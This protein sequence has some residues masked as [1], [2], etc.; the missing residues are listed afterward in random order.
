MAVSRRLRFEV[1]RRDGHTCRYCGA[2]APDVVLTVD[3]VIPTTLGGGDEPSNLVTACSDCNAGKSSIAPGSPLVDDVK[4]SALLWAQAI[5]MA[6]EWRAIDRQ[7]V[8]E[9]RAEFDQAW[10]VWKCDGEVIPRSSDW[11]ESVTRFV[12]LGIYE[13]ELLRLIGVA[14]GKKNIA[15]GDVWRYFCG[16]AW[17]AITDLQETARQI[18]ESGVVRGK[19]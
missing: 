5:S 1:L 9:F 17:R 4:E 8:E 18:I 7:V 15:S 13:E 12:A 3:H 2:Q 14:M 19:D 11:Q 16:C 6:A 10:S